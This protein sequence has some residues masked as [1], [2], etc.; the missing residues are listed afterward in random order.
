[1][2]LRCLIVEDSRRFLDSARGLLERQG[3]TVVGV[4]STSA[5]A[6]RL[7]ETPRPDVTLIDIALGEESG[8]EQRGASRKV[9]TAS[10]RGG[11]RRSRGG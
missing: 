2:T 10:R 6:L 3:I 1:M 5:E 9:T 4:A 11:R 7:T 8:F